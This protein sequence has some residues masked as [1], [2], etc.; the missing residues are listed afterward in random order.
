MKHENKVEVAVAWANIAEPGDAWAG[1]L[2]AA[3]GPEDALRWAA[4][5]Y[6]S[7][8]SDVA[9]P[10]G[11]KGGGAASGWKAAH[12]RW[13]PRFE[14][15]DPQRDLGEL[16]KL[17]GRLVLPDDPQWPSQF[18][19]LEF[20]QPPA[21]WVLGEGS[22]SCQSEPAVSV[23][24][25]RAATTYGTRVAAQMAFDLAAAGVSVVSGGAYGIDAAAH[26]GA[27]DF[28][29]ESQQR[30]AAR[31]RTLEGAEPACRGPRTV[32]IVCGGLSSLYPAGNAELF[33]RITSEGGVVVAEVPPRF[34]P[35]RWRFL[36]RNRLIAAWSDVTVVPEAGI[37]SGALA[38]ANRALELGREVA[39]VPGPVTSSVSHGPHS[40]I[41]D[42]AAL[43]A[44]ARDV[45]ELLVGVQ[46]DEDGANSGSAQPPAS[47]DL[48]VEAQLAALGPVARRV[49][50]ALP[51]VLSAPLTNVARAAGLPTDQVGGALLSLRFA[52]LVKHDNGKWSRAA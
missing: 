47:G 23:V 51:A 19:E 25:A 6:A 7:L 45:I 18:E 14:D 27:L 34:R 22:L 1:A 32:A 41:R 15:L 20:R 37:R 12:R 21:L 33:E 35:A 13:E 5:D 4:A 29:V 11:H 50:E 10:S 44:S 38:T 8:P 30:A 26:R 49:Y 28:G 31:S 24:G 48:W 46:G 16:E 36:E 17:G 40:L 3:L 2:R 43:V 42:G 52:D 9:A 39:A